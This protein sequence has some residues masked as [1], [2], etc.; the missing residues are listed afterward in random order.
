MGQG[1]LNGEG[2]FVNFLY[3]VLVYYILA[4]FCKVSPPVFEKNSVP[5]ILSVIITMTLPKY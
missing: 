1:I 5:L 3:H 2:S 4:F